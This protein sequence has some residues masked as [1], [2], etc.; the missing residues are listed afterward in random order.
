[1]M[2]IE[3]DQVEIAIRGSSDGQPVFARHS[4]LG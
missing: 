3:K 2:M 1:M 4:V